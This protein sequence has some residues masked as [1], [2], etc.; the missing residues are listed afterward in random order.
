MPLKLVLPGLCGTCAYG[1]VAFAPKSKQ[2]MVKAVATGVFLGWSCVHGSCTHS[3]PRPHDMTLSASPAGAVLLAAPSSP[4]SLA[5]PAAVLQP[6]PL[7]LLL[8]PLSQPAAVMFPRGIADQCHNIVSHRIHSSRSS[9]S[10]PL[11]QP[12]ALLQPLLL[13]NSV[14]PLLCSSP[15][16]SL[17]LSQPAALLQPLL[18]NPFDPAAS[19]ARSGPCSVRTQAENDD[20]WKEKRTAD[21]QMEDLQAQLEAALRAHEAT[22]HQLETAKFFLQASP[23]PSAPPGPSCRRHAAT[24]WGPPTSPPADKLRGGPGSWEVDGPARVCCSGPTGPCHTSWGPP[25]PSWKHAA[26]DLCDL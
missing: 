21:K 24:S 23:L 25:G 12:A 11:S 13:L 16:C 14:A 15:R 20:L 19:H 8:K 6:C 7:P 3:K 22:L 1:Q 4:C 18:P 10:L 17:P 5:P 2:G 9:C 26:Q